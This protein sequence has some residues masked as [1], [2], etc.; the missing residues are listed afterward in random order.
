[1]LPIRAHLD[2]CHQIDGMEQHH[3]KHPLPHPLFQRW[4]APSSI[5]QS[6][7]DKRSPSKSAS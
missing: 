4:I 1:L 3:R 2:R 5:P 6:C 7:K